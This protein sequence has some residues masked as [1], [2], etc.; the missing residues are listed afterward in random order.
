MTG[1][2]CPRRSKRFAPHVRRH[3][4]RAGCGADKYGDYEQGAQQD[5]KGN[6]N[7]QQHACER[8]PVSPPDEVTR[9]GDHP[10]ARP[11]EWKNFDRRCNAN[12][13]DYKNDQ[14]I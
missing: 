10:R 5:R 7:H 11:D 4:T 6:P 12:G 3:L 1:H 9:Q 13:A 14:P 8:M 2:V